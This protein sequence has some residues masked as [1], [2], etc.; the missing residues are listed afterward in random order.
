MQVKRKDETR[1]Q[2]VQQDGDAPPSSP[3]ANDL[4]PQEQ[5]ARTCPPDP[6]EFYQRLTKRHDLRD[7]LTRLAK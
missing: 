2:R 5:D 6:D 1:G 3:P 4:T 7:L